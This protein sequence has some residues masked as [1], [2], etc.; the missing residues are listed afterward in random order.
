MPWRWPC[1]FYLIFADW[2][3]LPPSCPSPFS[4]EDVCFSL[5]WFIISVLSLVAASALAGPGGLSFSL[6]YRCSSFN[7]WARTQSL[8]LGPWKELRALGLQCT[9]V[10]GPDVFLEHPR[11]PPGPGQ[12]ELRLVLR[13]RWPEAAR[14]GSIP[15]KLPGDR[16]MRWAE[17][18]DHTPPPSSRRRGRCRREP[19][20]W[21][22]AQAPPAPR[23]LQCFDASA[24]KKAR[25]DDIENQAMRPHTAAAGKAPRGQRAGRGRRLPA[26][27]PGAERAPAVSPQPL[28]CFTAPLG[29]PVPQPPV[30][31]LGPN[32]IPRTGSCEEPFSSPGT[33][34]P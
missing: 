21:P 29:S 7:I 20:G 27:G 13:S 17:P 23:L 15:E 25:V 4:R 26:E 1:S 8:G 5:K 30:H 11:Q 28:S 33:P 22:L 12:E 32:L 31:L 2:S 10:P 18:E 34:P 9:G 14:S 24:S 6:K 3:C 16:G 19:R